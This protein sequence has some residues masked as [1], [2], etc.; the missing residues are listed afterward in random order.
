MYS[1]SDKILESYLKENVSAKMEWDTTHKL[2]D[3]PRVTQ[4][5]KWLRRSSLDELPQVFNA[6]MGSMSLVGPRPIVMEEISKYGDHFSYYCMVKPG[7]TGL[8]QVSGRSKL[9]YAQRVDLDRHYVMEWTLRNDLVILARTFF[10]VA[11][12]DGAC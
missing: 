7:V 12:G 5:G 4:V 10:T 6:L 9:S 11:R 1:D 8:W 3:D 2:V